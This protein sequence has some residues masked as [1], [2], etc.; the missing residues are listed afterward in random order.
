[1]K[2]E[3]RNLKSLK[4]IRKIKVS[5]GSKYILFFPLSSGIS[6]KD[7]QSLRSPYFADTNFIVN[8]TDGIKYIEIKDDKVSNL[9]KKK[10]S[11]S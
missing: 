4:D 6:P 8:S 3:I 1:M 5:E 7:L 2:R 11:K 9:S 10:R